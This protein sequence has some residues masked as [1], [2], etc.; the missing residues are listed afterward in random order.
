MS[1]GRRTD[2]ETWWWNEEGQEYVQRKRLSKK[3]W[4]TERTE[5]S[6]REYRENQLKVR[7]EVA[8]N[9]DLYTRLDS[10]EGEYDLYSLARQR[11]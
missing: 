3:K 1:S 8:N 11:N 9:E 5:E 10:K 7:V 2:K 4:D 6:R